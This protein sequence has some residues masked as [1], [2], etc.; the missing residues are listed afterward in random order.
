M[1]SSV[2]IV[3]CG[4]FDSSNSFASLKKSKTRK[5]DYFELEC[6]LDKS[7]VSVVNQK[8]YPINKGDL[9]FAKP[10]DLRYSYLH[11]KAYYIHFIV[12]DPELEAMLRAFPAFLSPV[13]YR[14][15]SDLMEKAVKAYHSSDPLG[16]LLA[17]SKLVTLL[18][19]IRKLCGG[20][21]KKGGDV[22]CRAKNFIKQ[23]YMEDISVNTVA[24]NCN[25]SEPHLYR[26][27]KN[28]LGIS[29]NEYLLDLRLSVARGLLCERDLSISEISVECGFN[30]Q[31]YFSDCFKRKNGLS[32]S[33]YR[34]IHKYEL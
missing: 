22:L 7:G 33:D 16:K 21:A 8:K 9:L 14:S 5:V 24:K 2:K 17:L 15:S 20:E 27:F 31:S 3:R 32:P 34:Q 18:E 11:F 4:V 28:S 13:E 30:S 12:K 10:G 29:P 6:F 19:A 26:L 23:N 25:I 1:E